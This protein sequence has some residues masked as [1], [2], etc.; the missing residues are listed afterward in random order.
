M[1]R[2]SGAI[3]RRGRATTLALVVAAFVVATSTAR[4]DVTTEQSASILV[5][6]KVIS[7]PATASKL[8]S[9]TIIQISNTSNSMAFAHCFYVNGAPP[10]PSQLPSSTNQPQC[11]EIDFD[12]YLTKQQPTHWVV[13]TGRRV[14][15]TGPS[16]QECSDNPPFY[17]CNGAG[18]DPGA[19]PPVSDF[20]TGE[21]KCIEV[22]SSGAPINGN[23]LKGEA[24]I[25]TTDGDA[26]KYNAIG[27]M[28]LNTDS[29]SNNGDDTLCLGGGMTPSCP[30]GAEY[31]AC[32]DTLIVNHFAAGNKF[33]AG[34]SDP[35]INEFA[36]GSEVNTEVTIVPCTEDFENQVFGT[37]VVWFD[38]YN[39][40]EER[41]STSI[42]LVYCWANLNLGAVN[43]VFTQ[44]FLGTRF[45]QTRMYSAD[46]DQ[47]GILGVVEEFHSVSGGNTT[48][49]AL[50]LHGEGDRPDGDVLVLPGGF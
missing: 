9:D 26:S 7:T 38:I 8:A 36:S 13:S 14:S 19:I 4:A 12:I 43:S 15:S 50:N 25:V 6:P 29:N 35:V 49:D 45:A 31:N 39:E 3:W 22:D 5:F 34:A 32:P 28:G 42:P 47:S 17:D 23:H 1:G 20:F 24:T 40:F 30:T 2:A 33:S 48:R 16:D 18:F 41:Y 11:Q 10:D 44:A 46:P 37:A 27:V 21:L